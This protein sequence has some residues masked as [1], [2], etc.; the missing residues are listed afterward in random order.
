MRRLL[1][2]VVTV[3]TGL[4]LVMPAT[5]DTA[6][7]GKNQPALTTAGTSAQKHGKKGHHRHGKGQHKKKADTTAQK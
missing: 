5:A 3:L 2:L 1:A 4:V 6:G 7:F